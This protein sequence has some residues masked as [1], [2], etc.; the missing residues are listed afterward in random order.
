[1]YPGYLLYQYFEDGSLKILR[2]VSAAAGNSRME[3]KALQF[4]ASAAFDQDW[5]AS[6]YNLEL[7]FQ[8]LWNSYRKT[9]SVLAKC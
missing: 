8:E 9:G 3:M 7:I 4:S 5:S 2:K 1:M 6:F